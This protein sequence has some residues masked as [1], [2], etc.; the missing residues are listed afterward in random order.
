MKKFNYHEVLSFW[1][2][3]DKNFDEEITLK[4]YDQCNV[5]ALKHYIKV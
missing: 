1:F 4:F 2:A 5:I 3:K